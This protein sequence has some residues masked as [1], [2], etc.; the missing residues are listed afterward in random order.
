MLTRIHGIGSWTE[1]IYC[2]LDQENVNLS[3]N[4]LKNGPNLMRNYRNGEN[5]WHHMKRMPHYTNENIS[6][7]LRLQLERYV[8]WIER[9]KGEIYYQLFT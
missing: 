7:L 9:L 1:K 8:I 3:Q 2:C 6:M 4:G 5:R